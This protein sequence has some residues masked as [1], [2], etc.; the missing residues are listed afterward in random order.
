V[1]LEDDAPN[2][3]ELDG[4]VRL[5]AQRACCAA[6]ELVEILLSRS[7]IAMSVALESGLLQNLAA[8]VV[9]C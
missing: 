8:S 6:N 5:R 2:R 4:E 7:F 9:L 1:L 3:R